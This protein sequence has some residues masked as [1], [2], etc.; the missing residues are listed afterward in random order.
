MNFLIDNLKNRFPLIGIM[1]NFKIFHLNEF[2]K[3]DNINLKIESYGNK[4]L[5]NILEFYGQIDNSG[6]IFLSVF[7]KDIIRQE[8]REMKR[9]IYNNYL[10]LETLTAWKNVFLDTKDIYPSI[11]RLITLILSLPVS[12]VD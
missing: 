4:E 9:L 10:Q 11:Y 8:W 5:D 1:E 12:T 3:I 7:D 2:K 6:K